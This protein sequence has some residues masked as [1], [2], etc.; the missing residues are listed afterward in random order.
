MVTSTTAAALPSFEQ[1][2]AQY[3]PV[4]GLKVHVELGTITKLFC[5]CST[6]FGAGTQRSGVPGLPWSSW[7]ATGAQPV[8]RSS[9]AIRLGARAQLHHR[10]MGSR[11]AR[12]NYFYPD[13]PKNFQISQYDEPIA[14]EG[15]L[16]ITYEGT[17]TG[18]HRA[19]THG[20]GHR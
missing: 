2:I 3:D 6:E 11:F 1:A 7:L 19:G 13:M 14:Y 20:G 5:G 8:R 4:M 16:D 17:H 9:S 18:S 10:R 12:K 15:W